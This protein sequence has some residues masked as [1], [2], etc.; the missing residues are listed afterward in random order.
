MWWS[1]DQTASCI[2]DQNLFALR[3][4]SH[5]KMFHRPAD[6]NDPNHVIYHWGHTARQIQAPAMPRG[7]INIHLIRPRS[8]LESSCIDASIFSDWPLTSSRALVRRV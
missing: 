6:P 4:K 2:A 7:M 8:S 3:V 1:Q 5:D